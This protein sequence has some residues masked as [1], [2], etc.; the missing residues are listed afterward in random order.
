MRSEYTI[1]K[2][3]GDDMYSWAVFYK[4]DVAGT[5]GVV[6]YGQAK[7]RVCGCGRSEAMYYKQQ[8]EKEDVS[9]E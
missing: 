2:F 3:D 5:R 1:R 6:F 9:N 4:R 7:P 8:F